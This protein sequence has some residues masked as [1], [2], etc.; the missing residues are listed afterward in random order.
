MNKR[1]EYQKGE[2]K[3]VETFRTKIISLHSQWCSWGGGFKLCGFPRH[4]NPRGSKI[5]ILNGE[6]IDSWP[7]TNFKS[8][9]QTQQLSK[10]IHSTNYTAVLLI[11]TAA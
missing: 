5:G 10:H 8:L 1:M 7:S 3:H 11:S 9:S 2:F 6:K 4:L